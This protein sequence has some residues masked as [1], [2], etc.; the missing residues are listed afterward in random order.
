[1][2]FSSA[3]LDP[4]MV[5]DVAFC[6]ASIDDLWQLGPPSA[7]AAWRPVRSYIEDKNQNLNVYIRVIMDIMLMYNMILLENTS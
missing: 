2:G 4:W 6:Q 7:D 3:S 5:S 1:M